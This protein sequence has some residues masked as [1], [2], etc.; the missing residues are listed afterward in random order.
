MSLKLRE[1]YIRMKV[2]N[3]IIDEQMQGI[4]WKLLLFFVEKTYWQG[5]IVYV[6]VSVKPIKSEITN[7]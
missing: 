3:G 4:A 1:F 7:L 2:F 5:I 6:L